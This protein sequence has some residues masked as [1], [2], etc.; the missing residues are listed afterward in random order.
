MKKI[1]SIIAIA[2]AAVVTAVSCSNKNNPEPVVPVGSIS[3]EQAEYTV[4]VGEK[5]TVAVTGLAEG[6]TVKSYVSSDR[7]VATVTTKGV[8]TGKKVGEVTLTATSSASNTATCTVKV[9]EKPAEYVSIT[10]VTVTP[11][12]LA[13]KENASE[14]LSAA[15]APANATDKDKAI[16]WKS[17]DESVVT[18]D[19]NGKVTAKTVPAG[20]TKTAEITATITDSYKNSFSGKC[21]VTVK[22]SVVPTTGITLDV[23]TLKLNPE[24]TR[25]L[26][27]SLVPADHTDNLAIT[28]ETTNASVAT[29]SSG[30]VT[31]VAVGSATITA[32]AGS[33][34]ATCEVEVTEAPVA[35]L[36][37]DMSTVAFPYTWPEA[38]E[39][40]LDNVTM[41]TWVNT[42]SLQYTQNIMGIE[43]VFLLRVDKPQFQLLYGTTVRDN[44]EY[45]EG[46]VNG[47]LPTNEWVH[48]A[49]TY[50]R[51]GKAILY[52]NGEKAGEGNTEDHPVD[53]NGIKKK[54]TQ[55]RPGEN[56]TQWGLIPFS[57]II[58]N[59]CDANRNIRGS[60][61]YARVWS[62]VR[63]A[64]EIKANMYKKAPEGDNLLANWFFDEGA[65]NAISDHSGNGRTLAPKTWSPFNKGTARTI[66]DAEINWIEGTLPAVK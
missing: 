13:L 29:V 42:T 55:L 53:M 66:Q 49:A 40:K 12:T 21:V 2:A 22:S 18:V 54:S 65:G 58:G 46:K 19:Q 34:S 60:I 23:T 64:D 25:Q 61:A 35:T 10:G 57:F 48:I 26:T 1:F 47:T 52:I 15:V 7:T 14:T 11:A 8:V 59:G 45:S 20:E 41:E 32:K 31:A 63:T 37:A 50:A 43:G 9:M 5:V 17:S 39:Y 4:F 24:G 51:A 6:E 62:D 38:D 30:L 56:D 3:F 28:W 27:A 33:F 16:V 36:V 44:E